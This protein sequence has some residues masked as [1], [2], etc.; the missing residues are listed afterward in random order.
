MTDDP[1][2]PLRARYVAR[3]AAEMLELMTFV[4][5]DRLDSD[6]ARQL[7]HGLA[8]SGATFGF[9]AISD[10]AQPLDGIYALGGIPTRDDMGPLLSALSA[11]LT[12]EC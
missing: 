9:P 4:A 7:I 6:R 5:E 8:G 12:S 2:A 3:T 11:S 1:M 10:A